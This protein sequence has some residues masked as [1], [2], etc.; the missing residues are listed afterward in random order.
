MIN[1][2]DYT[3]PY[4]DTAPAM[5]T[6]GK[7]L[8]CRHWEAGGM[9]GMGMGFCTLISD[10][11]TDMALATAADGSGDGAFYCDAEFGCS[12]WQAGGEDNYVPENGIGGGESP[13]PAGVGNEPMAGDVWSTY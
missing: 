7:C 4:A 12:L 9:D 13:L 10:K 1:P 2:D 11:Q 5:A 3:T 6:G 8:D